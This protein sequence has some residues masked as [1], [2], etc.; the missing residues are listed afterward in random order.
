MIQ[1]LYQIE[2]IRG[3]KLGKGTFKSFQ[4]L[5]DQYG[6]TNHDFHRYLQLKYYL[7]QTTG[8]ENLDGLE[9]EIVYLGI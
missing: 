5:K 7:E 1:S 2:Q 3:L 6:L 8:R 9:L 4:E